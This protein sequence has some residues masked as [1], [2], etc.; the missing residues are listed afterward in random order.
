MEAAPRNATALNNLAWLLATCPI[1]DV[2]DPGRAVEL[3]KA[4]VDLAPNTVNY[5]NTLGAA[6][7]RAGDWLAAVAALD[8][9]AGLR[10]RPDS[11]D[12]FFMAMSHWRLGDKEQARRSYDQAIAALP[13]DRLADEERRRFRAEAAEL[14]GVKTKGE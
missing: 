5:W 3:A 12:G 6:H 7:Y 10:R 8:K 1:A 4:A 14:L 2:R 13:P 11:D 9:A